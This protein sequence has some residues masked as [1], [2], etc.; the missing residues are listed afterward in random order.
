MLKTLRTSPDGCLSDF[1]RDKLVAGELPPEED[2]AA[3]AHNA[4]CAPCA[5]RVA[6]ARADAAR[7]ETE[8][9]RWEQIAGAAGPAVAK[10]ETAPAPAPPRRKFIRGLLYASTAACLVILTARGARRLDD[11]QPG[12]RIKGSERLGFFVKRAQASRVGKPGEV[13]RPGDAVQ[14]TYSAEAPVFLA[15]ISADAGGNVQ[16]LYPDGAQAARAPAGRDVVLPQ[17][18]ILDDVIGHERVVGLFCA[19]PIELE[20]VRRAWQASAGLA[21]P[22]VPGGCRADVLGWEKRAP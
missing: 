4:T 14:F 6:K 15:I 11:Q 10:G 21:E 18:T 3:R 22:P 12:T 8:A 2:R 1:R 5:T 20:P 13:V 19:Q 17:S 9:P 7:F 16:T